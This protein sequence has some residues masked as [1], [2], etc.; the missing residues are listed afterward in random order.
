MFDFYIKSKKEIKIISKLSCY[1]IFFFVIYKEI[2]SVENAWIWH[3]YADD[4]E[5]DI[6]VKN[7]FII[8]IIHVGDII[9]PKSLSI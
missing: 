4:N 3:E 2:K 6:V 7:K 5:S 8:E 9:W 1:N